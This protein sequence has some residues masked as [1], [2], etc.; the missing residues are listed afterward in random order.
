MSVVTILLFFVYC[1]GLGFTI[2]SFVKNSENFLERNL[3]R[4]GFGL[5]FLPLLALILNMFKIPADWKIIL[6][7]SLIYPLYYLFR[8]YKKFN[9]TFKLTKTNLSIFIM[10]IIFFFNFYIYGTGAFN[11]PYL[12]DDDSWAHAIGVKYFSIEKNAFNEE[13][14]QVRYINPYPPAYDILLGILHQTNNSIYWTLKFFNALI[15]SLSTVFFYFL[16]KEF[17]GNKNKALFAT[18]ALMS[19]PAYMSHFIWSISIAVPLFFV[20]F[21]AAE[22]IKYDKKWWILTSLVMITPLISSPTHSTYFGIFFVLYFLSK[23][24]IEKKI[25]LYLTL[26]G[27]AGIFG[28]LIIWWGPMIIS[29]GFSGALLGVGLNPSTNS[30][31]NIGGTGD[32]IYTFTDFFIANKQNMINNPI[33]IGIVLTLLFVIGLIYSIFKYKDYLKKHIK[34][35]LFLFITAMS[36][37]LLFLSRAYNKTI[38]WGG[39][40]G[41]A[42]Q[43]IPFN[44]FLSDQLFVVLFI[45]LM[46]FTL[47]TLVVVRYTKKDFN[48]NYLITVII[49]LIFT[50]YAVNAAPYIFKLSP[51]RAWMLLAI[52]LCII[53]A[54]GA[55]GTMN[56]ANKVS[57]KFGKSIVFILLL[58]GIF[59]TSTQQKI[60]VNTATWGPGGFWTSNEEIGSY[61]WMKDNL[62]KNSN[63]FTYRN[64]A[65]V[66]GMDMYTCHWCDYVRNYRID[67]FNQSAQETYDW[68]K[69]KNYEYLIIDGLTV[70][71]FGIED[72]NEKI[73]ELAESGL[74]QP[75]L[76]NQGA[77]IF[78]I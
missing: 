7:L 12:E 48:D 33:G 66:I 75:V 13:T 38:W 11:Y 8:N 69:N 76:Q 59:F 6:V 54:E 20:V 28:S 29:Y 9:F 35:T 65:V 45:A 56:L 41:R 37:I 25:S 26:A 78:K 15:I 17:T 74:F 10:L 3:M 24:I 61:I 21:Y 4:I 50:F 22:R 46:V 58:T 2:S 40:A 68:L 19:I 18:F 49:W 55:I 31:T 51:F 60:A 42:E 47:V 67:G 57:G 64:S 30:V 62:P 39:A 53:V 71:K 43:P 44:V 72:S 73:R 5:S 70:R 14:K 16:V 36:A 77:V 1:Y 27:I 52:P 32:R 34:I 23:I 63:V